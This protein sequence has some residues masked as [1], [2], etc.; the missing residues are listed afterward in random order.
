[1]VNQRFCLIVLI[2]IVFGILFGIVVFA[3]YNTTKITTCRLE[4][5]ILCKDQ[6]VCVF[7]GANNTQ[8]REYIPYDAG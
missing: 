3:N 4:S 6:R 8:Y 2:L 7:V 5:K 1:M